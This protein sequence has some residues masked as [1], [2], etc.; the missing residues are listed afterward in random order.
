MKRRSAFTLIELLVVIAIIA[1][2]VSLLLPAVQQARE[3]A[4]RSQCKN[5]L[6]QLGLAAHN[7]HGSLN[8]FPPGVMS[9]QHAT[10]VN[11]SSRRCNSVYAFLLPYLD[12]GGLALQWDFTEPRN[13][14]STTTQ[15]RVTHYVLPVLVC[16]SDVMPQQRTEWPNGNSGQTEVYALT[17]YGGN[18]GIRSFTSMG[19]S[20][21][22]PTNDGAF[23][24]NSNVKLRDFLDGTTSTLLFGERSHVDRAYDTLAPS[25]PTDTMASKGWWGT[26]GNWV[27]GISDVTLS[28][29]VPIN[30]LH[31]AGAAIDTP[32]TERRLC[33]FG[34]SHTGGANFTLADGSVRFISESINQ[35][36][37]QALSTRAK[38]EVVG[39]F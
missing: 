24:I 6:R 20:S 14:V 39:E 18:G 26:S 21:P 33:A 1:V 29:L 9:W 38:G 17:S 25:V 2:L 15:P 31:P 30:Y 19:S 10:A 22:Q 5:N 16:P 37:L 35:A 7:Y 23:F 34:S 8:C 36:V 27:F 3:A 32:A 4:R 12:Q 13:N 11:G 28:T